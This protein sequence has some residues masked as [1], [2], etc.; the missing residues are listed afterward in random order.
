MDFS[1]KIFLCRPDSI[2]L[3]LF[4]CFVRFF[5]PDSGALT[6]K[7]MTYSTHQNFV[8][9]LFH[10]RGP[11]KI[12]SNPSRT[13]SIHHIDLIFQALIWIL[14]FFL[15]HCALQIFLKSFFIIVFLLF[16]PFFFIFLF[17]LFDFQEFNHLLSRFF[18]DKKLLDAHLVNLADDSF[19][20]FIHFIS[21]LS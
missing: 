11:N 9:A 14:V 5:L 15:V 8:R 16:Q 17:L 19:Q 18:G 13:H 4:D 3:L 20:L 10:R 21:F 7:Q 1:L 6:S 2:F 12:L